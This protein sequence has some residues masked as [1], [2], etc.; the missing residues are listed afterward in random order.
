M[1]TVKDSKDMQDV[2][3]LLQALKTQKLLVPQPDKIGTL[4]ELQSEMIS[5]IWN[6]DSREHSDPNSPVGFTELQKEMLR[7]ILQSNSIQ[8][9]LHQENMELIKNVTGIKEESK[10]DVDIE[11]VDVDHNY[12]QGSTYE[13][14]HNS[15]S[16]DLIIADREIVKDNHVNMIPSMRATKIINTNT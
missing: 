14:K 8:I 5:W 15:F 16:I 2:Y 3:D 9:A 12:E 6:V 10:S 4:T 13:M 7:W 11:G 1:S